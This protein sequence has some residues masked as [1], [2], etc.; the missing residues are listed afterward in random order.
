MQIVFFLIG[1]R[2]GRGANYLEICARAPTLVCHV[3]I[4]VVGGAS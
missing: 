4:I 2:S 3:T 1:N